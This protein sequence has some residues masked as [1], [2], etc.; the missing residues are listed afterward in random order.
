MGPE[1]TR[2]QVEDGRGGGWFKEWQKYDRTYNGEPTGV[3]RFI[4]DINGR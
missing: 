1:V 3:Y 4:G 2:P